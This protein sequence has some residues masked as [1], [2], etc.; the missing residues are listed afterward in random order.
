MSVMSS[1]CQNIHVHHVKKLS[2]A[3]TFSATLSG[4]QTVRSQ[5]L[6]CQI[7]ANI[8]HTD[9]LSEANACSVR[10]ILRP[11]C[12][13]TV[14]GQHSLCHAVRPTNCQMPTLALSLSDKHMSDML[15]N[16]QRP[17]PC[18]AVGPTNC[19]LP[20]V[21]IPQSPRPCLS[22]W[23]NDTSGKIPFPKQ[24]KWDK[25]KKSTL[26]LFLWSWN[27]RKKPG[28]LSKQQQAWLL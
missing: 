26:P 24:A 19:Q 14:R 10:H 20:T 5:C 22:S 23:R 12:W 13:Q 27:W 16:C 15:T 8:W 7:N 1:D 17:T 21:L 2:E 3:N 11:S 28:V 6:L 18:Q 9:K 4:W 25:H